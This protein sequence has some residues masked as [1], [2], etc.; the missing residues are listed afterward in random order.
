MAH[1]LGVVLLLSLLLVAGRVL[2]RWMTN[3][4]ETAVSMPEEP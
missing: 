4:A 2:T 3:Y 1:A